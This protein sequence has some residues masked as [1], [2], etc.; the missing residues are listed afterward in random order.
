MPRISG[1]HQKWGEK[2]EF[3][4]RG[5]SESMVLT[6]AWFL[7]SRLQNYERIDFCSFKLPNLFVTAALGNKTGGGWEG[8]RVCYQAW[9][10]CSLVPP[11]NSTHRFAYIPRL[12]LLKSTEVGVLIYHFPLVECYF[13]GS[14]FIPQPFWSAKLLSRAG[15]SSQSMQTK[16]HK[17]GRW[18]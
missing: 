12:F 17:T 6:T 18:N 2:A 7:N 15:S 3:F 10:Y 13:L 16:R 8:E 1:T 11:G 4:S 9:G 5:F 14:A